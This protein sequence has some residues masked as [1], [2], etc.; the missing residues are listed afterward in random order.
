MFFTRIGTW[1]AHF[2]FWLGLMRVALGFLLAF[3]TETQEQN[4][5]VAR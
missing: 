4:R 3:G 1:I 2:M 5:A